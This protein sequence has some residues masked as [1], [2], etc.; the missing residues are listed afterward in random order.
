[1][2]LTKEG[3]KS[4]LASIDKTLTMFNKRKRATDAMIAT[5][6]ADKST[7]K[8]AA[9]VLTSNKLKD[10]QSFTGE[11]AKLADEKLETLKTGVTTYIA[12]IGTIIEEMQAYS[13][14]LGSQIT[15][16]QNQRAAVSS[17]TIID[18]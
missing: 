3:R 2:M 7:I 18:D 13:R 15:E 14:S 8:S 9:K 4:S 5:A 10:K 6:T 12:R 1:M 16:L 17:A 11:Q